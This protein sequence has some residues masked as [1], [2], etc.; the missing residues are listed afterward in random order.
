MAEC[1]VPTSTLCE[2]LNITDT[3]FYGWKKH[4]SGLNATAISRLH[5]LERQNRKLA[6]QLQQLQL[7]KQTLQTA[8]QDPL[9]MQGL[10]GQTREELIT[11]ILSRQPITRNR[12][13]QL[14]LATGDYSAE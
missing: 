5:Q 6:K 14:L 1:G 13:R 12:A 8:L 7:D 11:R 10:S 2:R 9:L 3:T 4:Y